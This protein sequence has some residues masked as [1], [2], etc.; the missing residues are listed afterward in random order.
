MLTAK[1]LKCYAGVKGS[2]TEI[3]C[4]SPTDQSC[5]KTNVGDLTTYGCGGSG[6]SIGCFEILGLETCTCTT[7]LCNSAEAITGKFTFALLTTF[8]LKMLF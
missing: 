1:A 5:L 2:Q 7:D 6:N 8:I 3:T 4:S